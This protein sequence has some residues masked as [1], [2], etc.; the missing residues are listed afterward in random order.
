MALL[1]VRDLA[2][3]LRKRGRPDLPLVEQVSF[4]VEAGQTMAI[5]GESGSGKTL[6]CL[7]LLGLLPKG[8]HVGGSVR[9]DDEEIVAR[10]TVAAERLRGREIGM[11]FQDPRGHLNP[12][13]T[14]GSHLVDTLRHHGEGSRRTCQETAADLLAQLRLSDP[15]ALMR[16]YPHELSGGQSQRVM[17]ALALAARPRLLIADEATTALDVMVQARILKLLAGLARDRN[18]AVVLVTHDLGVASRQADSVCVLYAGRT[19]ETAPMADFF[20]A[21]R[22][23]YS[24]A[25]IRSMPSLHRADPAPALPDVMPSPGAR[26]A[27]CAFA[28]RCPQAMDR[29]RTTRPTLDGAVST[30]VACLSPLAPLAADRSATARPGGAG[31]AGA[32]T[33]RWAAGRS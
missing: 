22:H 6:T 14:I 19:V 25:L 28:P 1:A 27:G 2:I 20:A 33:D 21:P 31:V 17:I 24:A 5:V 26:P 29:C 4:A 10:G 32:A 30:A 23:P 11:V 18:L 12:V 15:P 7:A 16:R 8:S 13:R 9:F 3:S